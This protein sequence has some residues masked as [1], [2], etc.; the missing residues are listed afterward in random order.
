MLRH[1]YK[2]FFLSTVLIAVSLY[3]CPAESAEV[4]I[5]GDSQLKPV[6]ELIAGIEDA[7]SVTSTVKA[8]AD[9]KDNLESIVYREGAKAVVALGQDAVN[10]SLSLPESIP[11]IYALIINPPDTARGNITGVYMATPVSEYMS[12]INKYFPDI[13][14]VGIVCDPVTR[15]VICPA[16]HRAN[17]KLYDATN[18]YEFI[19]AVSG[20]RG[21]VDA[22]LLLPEKNLLSQTAIEKAFIF[23]FREKIP[24]IGISEKYVKTGS[25]FSLGFNPEHMERQIGNLIIKVLNRGSASGIPQSPP[26]RFTL[27]INRKTAEATG[28]RVPPELINIAE[29][30]YP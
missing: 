23:S 6:S 26:E 17:A 4:L 16:E 27:Y 8:P 10:I 2:Y 3:A 18:P 24:V 30:V 9:V 11:V 21:D 28:I 29:R 1:N 20:M 7:L 5:I 19:S 22:L 14:R 12:F 13:K 25:L 15:S